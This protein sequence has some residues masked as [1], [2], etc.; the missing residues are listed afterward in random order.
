MN[1]LSERYRELYNSYQCLLFYVFKYK[2]QAGVLTSKK[3]YTTYNSKPCVLLKV[4]HGKIKI[5]NIIFPVYY[6]V[7]LSPVRNNG[8]ENDL[9]KIKKVSNVISN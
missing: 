4:C 5:A 3:C 8:Y 2:H 6:K 9:F 7:K 1:G